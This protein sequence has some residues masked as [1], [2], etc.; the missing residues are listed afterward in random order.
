MLKLLPGLNVSA[1][2]NYDSDD[3]LSNNSW[4]QAA[5][6]L[7]WNLLNPA[8]MQQT[9]AY[10]EVKEA[11]DNLNRQV[12]AMT[13]LTQT[14][15]GWGRYQGA[16]ETY[17]L[18]VEISDVAQKLAQ[19][20]SENAKTDVLAEAEK[21][22]SAARALFAQLRT[23]M[24]FAELQDATGSVFVTLGLDPLPEDFA[25]SDLG[26]ISR[27]LERVMTAWDMGRFT[28]EDYPRLP[29]VP[30]HRPPVYINAKLP[31]Q[32]VT[33]DNRFVMTIP[34]MTFAEADLGHQV[35]YTA[36]M[37]DGKPLLPWLFLIPKRLRCPANRLPRRKGFMKS[38]LQPVTAKDERVYLYYCT[39]RTR[40]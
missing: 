2:A 17:Q 7:G 5:A 38:R 22:S 35:S 34:P 1:S 30:M 14:H 32:K 13:V 26:T 19:Q 20:A 24:N 6:Q 27:A 18:S 33:E 23:A 37:R 10:G 16:K 4:L 9:L 11:V 31:M 21:I 12:I 40:L 25:S 39:G 8:R 29:P 15:I 36:T 28:N 3:F